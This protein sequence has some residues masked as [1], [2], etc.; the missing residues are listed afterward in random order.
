ME[1]CSF[2][3][4]LIICEDNGNNIIYIDWDND[5]V[6]V[7]RWINPGPA[8]SEVVGKMLTSIKA[9]AQTNALK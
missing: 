6:A 3:A 2:A 7:M 1:P 8:L 5:I 9:P 4:W